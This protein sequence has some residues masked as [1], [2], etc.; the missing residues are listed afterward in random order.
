MTL[1]DRLP[2]K[3]RL[4]RIELINDCH[5]VFCNAQLETREHLFLQCPMA[6]QLWNSVFFHSGL[7]FTITSWDDFFVWASSTWKGKSLLTSI[8]KLALN[9]LIYF[10]WEERNKRIFKGCSRNVQE[11]FLAIK[12]VVRFQL[13]D[14]K[15]NRNDIAN[16]SLCKHW[17]ISCS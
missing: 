6:E 13:R 4:H 7:Q 17:D 12:D 16:S 5:C 3:V 8:M 1:L 2:T 14:R 10:L 9:A 15:I 11:L